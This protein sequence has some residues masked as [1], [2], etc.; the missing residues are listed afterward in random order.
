MASTTEPEPDPGGGGRR[1]HKDDDDDHHGPRR[2]DPTQA[3]NTAPNAAPEIV[4]EER[5]SRIP[6]PISAQE[7]THQSPAR[8]APAP[9]Q[10]SIRIRSHTIGSGSGRARVSLGGAEGLD[11][12]AIGILSTRPRSGS[13][14]SVLTA[15]PDAARGGL[16]RMPVGQLTQPS[17]AHLP[18]LTEEGVRPS[19]ADLKAVDERETVVARDEEA[20]APKKARRVSRFLWPAAGGRKSQAASA[21]PA[22]DEGGFQPLRSRQEDEYDEQLVDWLD[23]IDPEVQTLSTLTNVQNSLFVPDL[24]NWINR[25]P[26]YVLSHHDGLLR[27]PASV[28]GPRMT[29][30]MAP[31]ATPTP[32]PPPPPSTAPGADDDDDK[33]D[34]VTTAPPMRRSATITSRLSDSHYAALPHGK[35]L[36]GWSAADKSELDDHVRHMLHS[37]RARFK[38]TMK[39]FGQYVRRPLG[40]FVT[41]YATLITLF[42][43][44]WVLFLIG[45]IY[46]GEKQVYAIHII[47][48]VL[49]ALFAIMG[50]GLAPFRAIDTYHMIFVVHYM[51]IIKAA[52]RPPR[53]RL[54]KRRPWNFGRRGGAESTAAGTSSMAPPPQSSSSSA[55]VNVPHPPSTASDDGPPTPPPPPTADDDVDARTNMVVIDLEDGK[56][57]QAGADADRPS[58]EVEL[59]AQ[60]TD[61]EIADSAAYYPLTPK[62]RRSLI[63]H[64]QKLSK[65]HSFYKPQETLTHYSF[66][67]AYLMAIVILLDCHSCLQISLGACTWGIDYHVRPFALTTVILC[68]SISCNLSAGIVI[69]VGDRRTRK[70][71]VIRLLNRQELTGDA[72]KTIE[73]RRQKRDER[74]T[75]ELLDRIADAASDDKR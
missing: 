12:A 29:A 32:A 62:Q 39:G 47:D 71:D 4:V 45:W 73:H 55:P 8:P 59:E 63:H 72:I 31:A 22:P 44:A 38:R 14:T 20:G 30:P 65:S 68:V 23:I 13:Q 11:V 61:G 58:S 34:S 52:S 42:G 50:D 10:P 56:S 64:Q 28:G 36:E 2:M 60:E 5:L 16:R 67:L 19:A 25:R 54:R 66:P 37:R 24:G 15:P 75:E 6:S 9:R 49:V 69:M 17:P 27:R 40:F 35:T 1:E 26:T 3:T 74:R 53:S 51:R 57:D 70:K 46:V 43:L 48:S 41:L 7:V 33:T 21:S 18:R